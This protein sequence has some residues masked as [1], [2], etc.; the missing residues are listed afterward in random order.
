MNG[1]SHEEL[2]QGWLFPR[3]TSSWRSRRW[4]LGRA[5][6][7]GLGLVVTPSWADE[8]VR[9][10]F[11]SEPRNRPITTAFP[12]K[13]PLIL[14]RTRPPLLETPMKVFDESVLTPNDKFYVRWHW[15]V[16]P[17]T[18]DVDKFRLAVRGHVASTLSLSLD[19]IL[20]MP[21]VELVAVNQ[22]SGNSRGYFQPRVPGA[23]WSN[24]A[25]G[26]ARWTGV[27]LKDVLSRAGVK[28]GAVRVRF[29][30]LDEPVVDGAPDFMKSLDI[31]H[32]LDGKV[33]IAFAMNGEQ[34][35][36]L[37][38]F[39]LRL[40]VPGWYSTYW[41]KM[42]S[43]I[44]VLDRTDDNFWMATAYTIPDTP[45]ANV[46]PG[47]TG[48]KLVPI[49]RM[50]PRSFITNIEDGAK[51]VPGSTVHARGIAFGGDTGVAKVEFS[52]DGGKTWQLASLGPDYGKYSFRRWEIDFTP[53]RSGDQ[54]L[55]VKCTNT[56][57][58]AQPETANW[59][60]SGFMRS[61]VEAVRV[62]VT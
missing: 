27:R 19:E 54:T 16:I 7:T 48:V 12:E 1:S 59:N 37:N 41:V 38:G 42:L 40:I 13:G 30:G 51:I 43:D 31:D 24:G 10:L 60:P 3:A 26:N 15:A 45:F 14:Q 58:G 21:R 4:L 55:M 57:N 22:C 61:V 56:D 32:A 52:F 53:A 39:P 2:T 44:E 20:K 49:N 50:G 33:M 25:M 5:G 46:T 47:E 28:A 23:Q 29:N 17:E 6:M 18:I 8:M 11:P 62:T 34:L 9:F 36:L 35:P